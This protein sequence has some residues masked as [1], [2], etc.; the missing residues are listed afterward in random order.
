LPAFT[1]PAHAWRMK[2]EYREAF[3]SAVGWPFLVAKSKRAGPESR[4]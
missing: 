4:P 1:G 3:L 2:P